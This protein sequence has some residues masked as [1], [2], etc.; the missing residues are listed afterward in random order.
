MTRRVSSWI[1]LPVI[2]CLTCIVSTSQAAQGDKDL[3]GL[4]KAAR[5]FDPGISGVL[6]VTEE[7]GVFSADIS[8]RRAPV[9]VNGSEV[10]FVISTDEA[11]VFRG[12]FSGVFQP[13][14]KTLSGH[15]TQPKS[16]MSGQRFASPVILSRV[17]DHQWVGEIHPKADE[18][19]LFLKLQERE[20]GTVGAFL[21]NPERN[22]G[23]FLDLDH[24]EREGEALSFVGTFRGRGPSREM[25]KGHY[26]ENWDRIMMDIPNRGGTYVFER[27]TQDEHSSFYARARNPEPYIYAPPPARNDGWRTGTLRQAGIDIKPIKR[28]IENEIYAPTEDVHASYVHGILIARNGKLVFEEYFHGFH[29]DKTHDTRSASKSLTSTLIGAAIEAG[30][31]ITTTTPVFETMMEDTSSLNGLDPRKRQMTLEHLLTMSSGFYC[32]DSDSEAPGGEGRMQEQEDEPDWYRYTLNVPM[33]Y[34]PGEIGIYCSANPNLA[35]GVLNRATGTPLEKLFQNLIASPLQMDRYFLNLSPTDEPYM[36]G[37]IYWLPRDFLK[38]GQVMLD[39]G[40]WNGRRIVSREWAQRATSSLIK[41]RDR[42][43]GYQWW[44]REYEYQGKSL[45]AFFAGGNGGN[46]VVVVPDLDVVIAFF[47]GNYSDRVLFRAQEEFIPNYILP[48]IGKK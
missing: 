48:A 30:L 1:V 24:I 43:Y 28:L 16:K 9:S 13:G 3:V 21:R 5:N 17:G 26:D 22:I 23:V 15:W 11:G 41:I 25:A 29:R 35:G 18:F 31:P 32:D 10:T 6:T 19:T 33:A 45:P 20:D 27:I 46:I 38:L 37:G 34:E 7:D 39:G 40:I 14:R 47:G 44:V 36:G 42:D 12:A 8:G 4:W 2:I